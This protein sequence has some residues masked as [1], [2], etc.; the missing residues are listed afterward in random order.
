[1]KRPDVYGPFTALRFR[2]QPTDGDLE[3]VR[4]LRRFALFAQEQADRSLAI[5]PHWTNRNT[6]GK[7]PLFL[8]EVYPR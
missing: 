5:S 6:L 1:M 3:L 7:A 2:Y 4:G 8:S